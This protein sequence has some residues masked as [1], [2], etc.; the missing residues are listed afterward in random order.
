MILNNFK[1]TPGFYLKWPYKRH[2]NKRPGKRSDFFARLSEIIFYD[3]E[4][5]KIWGVGEGTLI[6][7]NI[8]FPIIQAKSS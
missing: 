3:Q 6:F 1:D 8:D 5:N 4:K 7:K 2:K